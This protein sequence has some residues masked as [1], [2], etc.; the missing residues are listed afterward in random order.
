MRNI[1]NYGKELEILWYGALSDHFPTMMG[2]GSHPHRFQ[3]K[4]S[5]V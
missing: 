2:G 5:F 4:Y 3:V 1:E